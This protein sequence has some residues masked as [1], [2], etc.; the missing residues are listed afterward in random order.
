MFNVPESACPHCGKVYRC[1]TPAHL[2]GLPKPGDLLVCLGCTKVLTFN[3]QMTLEDLPQSR[4]ALLPL[5]Q[6][7]Q[8]K[9]LQ[10][11]LLGRN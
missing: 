8:V 6:R 1:Q 4:W 2:T 9:S 11:T 3:Q 5:D 7:L 10:R